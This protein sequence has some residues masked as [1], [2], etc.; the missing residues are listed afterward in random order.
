VRF[1]PDPTRPRGR[2]GIGFRPE[3]IRPR[4]YGIEFRSEMIRSRE[5]G[6]GLRPDP[7]RPKPKQ[8]RYCEHCGRKITYK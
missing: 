4:E 1:S 2:Y 6:I 3:T 8:P 5:Y 7:T